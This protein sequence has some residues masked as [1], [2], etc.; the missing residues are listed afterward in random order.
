MQSEVMRNIS[1]LQ[2]NLGRCG[3]HCGNK[4]AF[5]A[6]S[7]FVKQPLNKRRGMYYAHSTCQSS[8]YNL[9]EAYSKGFQNIVKFY[10]FQQYWT[11]LVWT[12]RW[13]NGFRVVQNILN[14]FYNKI[15]PPQYAYNN[16]VRGWFRIWYVK[17][18]FLNMRR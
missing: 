3:P 10:D 11:C 4:F 2:G 12:L 8:I 14:K 6:R 18:H 9:H 1:V 5:V 16:I 17:P 13:W 15:T 7:C